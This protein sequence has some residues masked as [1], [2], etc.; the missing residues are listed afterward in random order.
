[1][2][3]ILKV[4]VFPTLLLLLSG[5]VFSQKTGNIKEG[6]QN[7]NIPKTTLVKIEVAAFKALF[8]ENA[9]ATKEKATYY[10]LSLDDS[11]N[12][13]LPFVLDKLKRNSPKVKDISM[14]NNM[15][16]EEKS[17]IDFLSFNISKVIVSG[18]KASV[19]CGY[20]EGNLSSSGNVVELKKRLGKW[21]VVSNEMIWIS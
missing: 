16:D 3:L 20:Y 12:Q 10:F 21:R 9:S 4:L 15:T 14:F 8:K 6:L 5:T 18:N 1:M 2:N 19:Y 13:S 7:N 17:E 11:L